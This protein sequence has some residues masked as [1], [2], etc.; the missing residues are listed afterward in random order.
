MK[1]RVSCSLLLLAALLA[2]A[3]GSGCSVISAPSEE[4]LVPETPAP[5]ST[6]KPLPPEAAVA[7]ELITYSTAHSIGL[8]WN[9]TG[10]TNHNAK[11]L[12]IYRKEGTLQWKSALPLARIDFWNQNSLSG[13]IFRLEPGTSYEVSLSIIDTNEDT[14]GD[15]DGPTQVRSAVIKTKNLPVAPLGGRTIHVAPGSGPGLGTEANPYL[16]LPAAEAAAQ[17]GDTI[18]VHAGTYPYFKFNKSGQAELLLL[19]KAAGDGV[20][21]LQAESEVSGS[22]IWLDGFTFNGNH[23][24]GIRIRTGAKYGALTNCSFFNNNYSI[25]FQTGADGWTVMDNLI[26]GD[27]PPTTDT[28]VGEGIELS[29]SGGHTIAYNTI[30]QVADGVSYPVSNTDIFSNDIF[31]VSDDFIENDGSSGTVAVTQNN[32]RIWGNRMA[33]SRNNGFSFQ[34][35]KGGPW[36]FFGNQL[37]GFGEGS[38]KFRETYTFHFFHNTIVSWTASSIASWNP[39]GHFLRGYARNNL[40]ISM[41]GGKLMPFG[42]TYLADWRTNLDFDGFDWGTEA[43]PFS[44]AGTDYSSLAAFS[45]ASGL[46]QHAV[47]IDR[48]AC[49][50][51]LSVVGPSPANP[52]PSQVLTPTPE[53][54]AIDAG[55]ILPNIND[56]FSG[57]A[58]DMGAVERGLPAPHFGKR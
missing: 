1:N 56:G 3:A 30:S 52:V 25:R 33:N 22:Y 28:D 4:Y 23:D 10:D 54:A 49:F 2:L 57:A 55:E 48:A 34:P 44:Y 14:D 46:Y 47:Q 39:W 7:G 12:V 11:A 29:F 16:G 20:V 17:P 32:V 40:W 43:K 8:E 38:I 50:P 13:S 58:P 19:W 41:T 5:S 24:Y 37:I 53:C 9:I 15:T 35:Q 6:P 27:T 18:S 36:Y 21:N 31:D 26:I 42:S 51:T 45:A